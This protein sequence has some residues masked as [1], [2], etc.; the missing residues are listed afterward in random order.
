MNSKP[1]MAPSRGGAPQV[2][3][4]GNE[5]L[6]K[7]EDLIQKYKDQY[8]QMQQRDKLQN[9]QPLSARGPPQ[10]EV[11]RVG[12]G[13]SDQK[14]VH[15]QCYQVPPSSQNYRNQ[16]SNIPGMPISTGIGGMPRGL[17]NQGSRD[18]LGIINSDRGH[19]RRDP[20]MEGI[21]AAA[22]GQVGHNKY[23]R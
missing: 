23:L 10:K 18:R 14:H 8:N 1:P 9:Q 13:L 19:Y 15:G 11:F 17:S 16:Q 22:G 7:R 21:V 6:N 5:Y 12:S 3:G 20:S 4:K 2:S